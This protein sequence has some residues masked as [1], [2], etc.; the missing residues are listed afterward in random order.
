MV[1]QDLPGIEEIID[2]G[3]N[4]M[5]VEGS[6]M[7]EVVRLMKVLLCDE[8]RLNRMRK[9][10]LATDVSAWALDAL[11]RRT[12]ALYGLPARRRGAMAADHEM[13]LA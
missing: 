8:R 9:E 12:T 1:V 4:G 3:R 11:G 6:D 13:G 10:A 7:D 2:H 5:V